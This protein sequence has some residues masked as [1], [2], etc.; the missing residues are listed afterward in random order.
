VSQIRLTSAGLEIDLKASAVL[1][2]TEDHSA[3][4]AHILVHVPTAFERRT[5]A[6]SIVVPGRE[7][8]A[9][10]DPSL[11]K[12]IAR[13]HVWFEQLASGEVATIS[14]IARRENVTDRYVS[15]LLKLAFLSPELV[16]AAVEGR[17]PPG[18]SAKR[19]TLDC[20]LPLLWTEQGRVLAVASQG[21]SR[22]G[23]SASINGYHPRE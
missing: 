4:S 14:E 19:L 21:S 15:V 8:G 2:T 9:S 12:A 7:V 11:M 13:G 23:E 6:M 3:A 1:E 20:D 17:A 22:E 18:L 5:G 16:Q 10:A